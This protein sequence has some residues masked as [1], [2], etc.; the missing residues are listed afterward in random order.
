M[1][2]LL[3]L[4]GKCELTVDG[5][6]SVSHHVK[7]VRHNQKSNR[8]VFLRGRTRRSPP[9]RR[10]CFDKRHRL[11]RT[12]HVAVVSYRPGEIGTH[13][14]HLPGKRAIKHACMQNYVTQID[15]MRAGRRLCPPAKVNSNYAALRRRRSAIPASA[16][17]PVSNR[18]MEPGSGATFEPGFETRMLLLV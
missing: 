12:D 1:R 10:I 13:T 3:R 15:S 18:A 14:M 4:L 5:V 17:P 6:S 9:T 11:S 7:R 8:N 16:P 2:P